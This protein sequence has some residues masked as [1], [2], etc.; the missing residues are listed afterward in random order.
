MRQKTANFQFTTE[1]WKNDK[2]IPPVENQDNLQ[3]RA[4]NE[5]NLLDIRISQSS[6]VHLGFEVFRGYRQKFKYTQI[7]TTHTQDT[8]HAILSVVLNRLSKITSET[9]EYY[10]QII[11]SIY[12][13]NVN[14]L[15]KSVLSLSNFPITI[16]LWR[17][18]EQKQ[19]FSDTEN[20]WNTLKKK[21][22]NFFFCIFY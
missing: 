16:Y 10:F 17:D 8:L 22:R 18:L 15:C 12:S 21:D 19:I 3:I 6:E 20:N 7:K 11:D 14:T 5:F 4:I 9:P 13:N 2:S 1:I